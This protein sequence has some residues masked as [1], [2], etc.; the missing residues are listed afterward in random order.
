[1]GCIIFFVLVVFPQNKLLI[2]ECLKEVVAEQYKSTDNS[3]MDDIDKKVDE[4]EKK[5]TTR[6]CPN[7]A[8]EMPKQKRI[9]INQDC[10]VNLKAAESRLTGEDI[11]GTALVDPVFR[12]RSFKENEVIFTVDDI[13]TSSAEDVVSKVTTTC[14]DKTVEWEHVTTGHGTQGVKLTVSD[15]VFVNPGSYKAVIEVLRSIGQAAKVTRYGHSGPNSRQWLSVTMDGSPYVLA[16]YIIDNTLICLQCAEN[17]GIEQV[18]FFG[19]EWQQH[20]KNCHNNLEVANVKEFDWVVL[21]IGPLHVEMNMVKTF[22]ALN[23]DVMVCELAK[24]LGF[25]SDS[26]LKYAKSAT[27]HHHAMTILEIL[28]KGLWSELLL[29]YVRERKVQ[30][31]A[32]SVNDFLYDW[33]ESVKDVNYLFIFEQL[34]RY[35][36]AIKVYHI[37]IRRNN[38][39]YVSAGLL[40]FAPM[41]SIH[42]YSSKYLLIELRDR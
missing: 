17:M 32:L 35:I 2:H 41:F 40:S 8:T 9:C 1:M 30:G 21:R 16:I 24:E 39:E 14:K 34:W 42:P 26:A 23:W 6:T 19:K 38:Y 4:I 11:L 7:C 18:S 3:Y 36:G 37:G 12:A 29:P 13:P 33:M 5:K 10:R 31:K 27:N 28:Q 25:T 22:F 15:P 20:V